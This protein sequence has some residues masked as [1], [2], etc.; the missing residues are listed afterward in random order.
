MAGRG[1][2]ILLGGADCSEADRERVI[3]AGGLYVIC[4]SMRESSR[5]NLQ[6]RGRTGRQGD[7]GESKVFTALGDDIMEKYE[8]KKLI[9][10]FKYPTYTREKITDKTVMREAERIQ[11]IS[12][13]DRLGERKRLLKFSHI[14][15]KHRDAIFKA[16]KKFVTGETEPKFWQNAEESVLEAPYNTAVEKFG[17]ESVNSLQRELILSV[18]N[19]AWS[20]YLAYNSALREGIHLTSVGGK[21]PVSEFNITSQRY[22][23]NM[24]AQ[25]RA[26]MDAGLEA[27]LEL[28]KIEDFVIAKPENTWTYLQNESADDL[29]KKPLMLKAVE[30]AVLIGED[31]ERDSHGT[32]KKEKP[33]SKEKGFWNSFFN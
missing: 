30:G 32:P 27:L 7:V 12:E 21:D 6:L 14:S 3:E 8:L 4:T 9:P 25:V 22:Y 11:R 13:G 5:I 17:G 1:V 31:T 20:E 23:E 2:D 19:E 18:I 29:V 24:E 16:R 10:R 15:E 26:E 28:D 33:L